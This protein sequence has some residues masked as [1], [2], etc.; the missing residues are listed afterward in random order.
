M[1][2]KY[3]LALDQGTTSSRSILF[4]QSGEIVEVSQ[5]E[6]SQIY[7]KSGWVEHDPM[8]ILTTQLDTAKDVLRKAGISPEEIASIGITNQR[9]T[10]VLWDKKTGEPVYNAIVW[11]CRR[12]ASICDSLKEKKL[13]GYVKE[14]TGLVIDA[15]FSG[16]KIKWILDNVKGAREKAL[17][18]DLIFGT[19]DTWLIWNLTNKEIHVTDYS[20]ASR[21]MIYNIKSLKWDKK[22]LGELDIPENLLP[23][24]KNSSE[25]YG[26]TSDKLFK[27]VSIPI[28]GIAGDQQ[29]ALFGQCCYTRGTAK[30]TYGTG[31]FMLMNTGKELIHSDKGL[32]STIAWGINGEVT[33][34]LEGS[35]FIAG[36]A[37]QWLRDEMRLIDKSEDSQYFAQKIDDNEGV[38]FV[39]AFSGLGAPHWD[40]Y[41]RGTIVGL[42]RSTSKNHIIRA[43]LESVAYQT[44]DVVNTMSEESGIDL[45][46]L[47]VDGG[48]T[49][50]KFLM[51]FQSDILDK[52]VIRPKIYETTALGAAYLAGL[53]VGFW[54]SM[55]EIKNINS[56]NAEYVPKMDK[57]KSDNYYY[58]WK[59]AL[60]KSK[61]W[62]ES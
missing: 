55:D 57:E 39:P 41:A 31:C 50:N 33:Y 53:S 46:L 34:A 22:L 40:M 15:Y 14:N 9:E 3:I 25:I 27:G 8:E 7:P 56:I 24:V 17:A 28:S 35:I 61:S 13:E 43:A 23:E 30:N 29:A 20:N 60:D 62:I 37:I 2:K 12:T 48:A 38:Y 44:K 10:T 36:A 6:F 16:T 54:E 32:L 51:Q 45:K 11:Q 18:G 42:T 49:N 1:E 26:K 19:I 58:N 52:K 5:K 47:K 21:T 59:R 4:N